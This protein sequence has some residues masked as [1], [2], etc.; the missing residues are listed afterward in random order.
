[1]LLFSRSVVSNSLQ[2]H[3]LQYARLPWASPSPWVCSDSCPLS[4]WGYLTI[5]FSAVPFSFRLQSFLASGSFS[6]NRLFASGGQTIGASASA[7]VLPM[8]IRGWFPLGLTGLIFLHSR[9]LSRVFSTTTIWKHQF[10][11]AQPSLWSNKKIL[12]L[13]NIFMVHMSMWVSLKWNYSFV[14]PVN[15]YHYLKEL[16]FPW[17]PMCLY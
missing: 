15:Y 7:S 2:P 6:M 9:G 1:M 13:F 4:W 17:K 16:S 11:S 10:F 12:I 3:G 14:C 8:T 5:S